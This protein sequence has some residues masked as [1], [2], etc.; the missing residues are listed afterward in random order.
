V[1]L[2][3]RRAPF[4][5]RCPHPHQPRTPAESR[6]TTS[7]GF[8]N[9]RHVVDV[10]VLLLL[11]VPPAAASCLPGFA[12]VVEYI[13]LYRSWWGGWGGWVLGEIEA[14]EHKKTKSNTQ[15]CRSMESVGRLPAMG[16]SAKSQMLLWHQYLVLK[17]RTRR[18]WS[19][20]CFSYLLHHRRF[21]AF[22]SRGGIT[23][24]PQTQQEWLVMNGLWE[25]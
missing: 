3:R 10:V 22:L 7:I 4:C 25:G 21:Q 9:T 13:A 20:V 8:V 24:F 19:Q 1:L 18:L 11:P 17:K 14:G 5:C 6:R 23:E 16:G 2:E 15:A 12:C